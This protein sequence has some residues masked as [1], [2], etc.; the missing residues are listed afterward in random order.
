MFPK[1]FILFFLRP[2]FCCQLI[3]LAVLPALRLTKREREREKGRKI[4]KKK[5][6]GIFAFFIIFPARITAT[7]DSQ[8]V[9]LLIKP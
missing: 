6:F 2:F 7:T 4:I 9:A 5:T 3:S 8:S 1:D